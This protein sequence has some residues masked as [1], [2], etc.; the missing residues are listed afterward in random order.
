MAI[1]GD[2]LRE[3]VTNR[4]LKRFTCL[5]CEEDFWASA[6]RDARF[7]SNACKILNH[8][9]KYSPVV[10]PAPDIHETAEIL[11]ATLP[12]K[13]DFDEAGNLVAHHG[14]TTFTIDSVDDA[15]AQGGVSYR[16]LLGGA[17]IASGAIR[18]V[19]RAANEYLKSKKK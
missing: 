17:V 9:E 18:A 4:K 14:D 3:A 1:T 8:R 12:L 15:G 6:S 2:F 5:I 19:E 13:W 16:L 7:C 11:S 10:Q